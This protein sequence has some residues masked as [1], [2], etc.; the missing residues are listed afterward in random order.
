MK[1]EGDSSCEVVN[2]GCVTGAVLDCV[3]YE[4]VKNASLPC[5]PY[6]STKWH[7][8]DSY[9]CSYDMHQVVHGTGNAVCGAGLSG[10]L[11]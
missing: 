1:V 4:R 7:V 9:N 5:A 10:I 11:G 6:G 2:F 8:H 3:V